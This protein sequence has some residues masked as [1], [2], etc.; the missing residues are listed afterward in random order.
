MQAVLYIAHGSRMKDARDAAV[1]TIMEIAR[2]ISVPIQELSFLELAEP[3]IEQGVLNC[4]KRGAT[5]I[6]VIPVLLL[7]AAHV[8][9]DIPLEL[10]RIRLKYPNVKITY[11]RPLGVDEKI[12]EIL[13]ERMREK[14]K[15]SKDM[16]TLLVG[17]GSNDATVIEETH[18]IASMLKQQTRVNNVETCFLAAANPRFED[19]LKETVQ[20][21]VKNIIVLPYL[22]F[23]GLLMTRIRKEIKKLVSKSGQEII[24]CDG[25]GHHPNISKLLAERV[26]EAVEENKIVI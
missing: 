6:A 9:K 13:V 2:G 10:D 26:N 3:T 4:I 12:I 15:I 7:A 23:T 1:N 22:L 5:K 17:R 16:T 8:K 11:G 19:A 24:L 18:H 21:R 20:A 14:K 25:L